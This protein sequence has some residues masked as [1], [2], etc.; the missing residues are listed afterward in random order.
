MQPSTSLQITEIYPSIQGE[1]SLTG[2]PCTFVRLTGCPLRCNW[3]DTAYAFEGGKTRTIKSIV[4]EVKAMPPRMVELTGGEP[5]AQA[6]AVDLLFALVES[7][8]ETM[9]ETSGSE[10]IAKLPQSTHVV[11]DLKCPDSKM[12]HR[13]L[14]ENIEHLK[15]TDDIKFVVASRADFDWAV[16]LVEQQGL[17][18]L[19]HVLVS[20]AF[21]L[22]KAEEL[23]G[24]ILDSGLNLRLNL[25]IHKYIWSPRKKGV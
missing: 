21:G 2:I 22:V 12:E 5:L 1:S 19:C 15:K 16:S 7:G 8:L 9:I 17:T 6:G 14:Y 20:P 24:W 4:E 10:S 18:D 3:C 23:V 13:N 25:Q 11:M